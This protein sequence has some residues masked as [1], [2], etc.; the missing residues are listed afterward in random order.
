MAGL[1]SGDP[2]VNSTDGRIERQQESTP[3]TSLEDEQ[4]LYGERARADSDHTLSD[5]DQTSSDSDQ[6]SADSE[7]LA[8]DRDQAAS[9]RDLAAGGDMEAHE[10]SREVRERSALRREHSAEARLNTASQRDASAH[11]RDLA[12]LARDR[13][14]DARDLAMA[15]R[16][17]AD[18]RELDE[19]AITGAE[20]VAEAARQRKRAAEDRAQ[21]AAQRAL[22][23]QDRQAAADDREQAARER[24]RAL[25]DR[26]ALARQVAIAETDPLTGAR[27]RAAGL[28]DLDHELDRCRRTGATLV[29]VYVDVVGLKILNDTEGHSAGDA[30]LRRVVRVIG[31]HL[32]S[33]DLIIRV[34]GD[35]FL[36]VMSNMTLADARRRFSATSA[37]LAATPAGGEISTGFAELAPD[38]TA[39][40][41]IARADRELIDGRRASQNGRSVL[42]DDAARS[43]SDR[44]SREG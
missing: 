15:Q 27:S 20:A 28:T 12:A 8:A 42:A 31:E 38:D 4:T 7:Q 41:L 14:A 10:L 25:V 30:L 29:V 22:A 33:Y 1:P 36:L 2:P 3:A 23:A 11:A 26:E 6:A 44:G 35:E 5:A 39:T 32:R 9:D 21:A 34:G 24:L 16:D 40:D 37:A 17:A 18:E 43:A 19:G 13:A